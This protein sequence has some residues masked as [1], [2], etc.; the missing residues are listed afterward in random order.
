MASLLADQRIMIESKES[1]AR[2]LETARCTGES[3]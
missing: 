1:F 2:T 3:L